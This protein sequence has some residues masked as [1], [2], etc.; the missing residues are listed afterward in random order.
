MFYD[1]MLTMLKGLAYVNW[2]WSI[3][4]DNHAALL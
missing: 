1:E 3:E 4:L 2:R